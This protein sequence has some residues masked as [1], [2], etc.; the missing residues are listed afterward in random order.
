[1][2]ACP[3][4]TEQIQDAAIQCRFCA[5]DVTAAIV[6]DSRMHWIVFMRPIFWLIVVII[7]TINGSAVLGTFFFVVMLVDGLGRLLLYASTR[8]QATTQRLSISTGTLKRQSLELVASKI[9]S[10]SVTKPLLGSLLGYGSV[11]VT[12]TGGRREAFPYVPDPE[13]FRFL[14]EQHLS[15]QS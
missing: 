15:S 2:K 14:I 3:Y 6:L 12:G 7:L 11:V 8:Y 9:E 1:M 10:V 5:S 13:R 4:C